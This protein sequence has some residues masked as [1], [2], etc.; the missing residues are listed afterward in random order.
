M[1]DT[2]KRSVNQFDRKREPGY[3]KFSLS[4]SVFERIKTLPYAQ[5]RAFTLSPRKHIIL[6]TPLGS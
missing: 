3:F 2:L 5:G 4:F 6:R 1:A